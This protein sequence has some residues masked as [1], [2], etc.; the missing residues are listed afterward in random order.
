MSRPSRRESK[1]LERLE[2]VAAQH[3]AIQQSAG[4]LDIRLRQIHRRAPQ[5]AEYI[6]LASAELAM[7]ADAVDGAQTLVAAELATQQQQR[8]RNNDS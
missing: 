4:L 5:V 1:M 6:E 3:H 7:L 8:S 2:G